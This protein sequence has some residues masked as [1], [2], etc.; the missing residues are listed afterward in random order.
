MNAC[1]PWGEP[2]HGTCGELANS[3]FTGNILIKERRKL[4]PRCDAPRE[5][6]NHAKQMICDHTK[7]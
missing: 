3:S 6:D 5:A 1:L 7:A 4:K 2:I